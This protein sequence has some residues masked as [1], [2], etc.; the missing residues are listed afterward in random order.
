MKITLF[1]NTVW[2]VVFCIVFSA[3]TRLYDDDDDDVMMM[4]MMMM[5]LLL[6]LRGR[7]MAGE[8]KRGG[9]LGLW[10]SPYLPWLQIQDSGRGRTETHKPEKRSLR[11]RWGSTFCERIVSPHS[12]P[13]KELLGKR[14]IEK[15]VPI[16]TE[17]LFLT[18]SCSKTKGLQS[19]PSYK[20]MS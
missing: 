7:G 3:L 15:L 5:L 11:E 17:R 10:F 6:L 9:V 18:L 1:Y 20:G 12:S 16:R 19:Q 13:K 2:L 14:R 8:G 4:T